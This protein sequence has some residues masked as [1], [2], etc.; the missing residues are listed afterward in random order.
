M[1][2]PCLRTALLALVLLP[3][4]SA[5]AQLPL[6]QI[7]AS[8]F[9]IDGTLRE[10][11]PVTMS[12]LGSGADASLRYAVAYDANGLYVGAEVHDDRMVRTA[13]PGDLEDA[14]V[15]TLAMPGRGAAL[16]A[17]E[18][19]LYAGQAGQSA[20]MVTAGPLGARRR[21]AVSGARIVEA[22]LSSG[23][24]YTLEA[25]I[26]WGAVTGHD[27]W[28]EGRGSIR[29]RDVDQ[30]AHPT[31]EAEP[32]LAV[33]ERAHL[34]RL[35][36]L[37]PSG[38]EAARLEEFLRPRDLSAA[39]PHHEFRIDVAGDARPEH[40]MLIDRFVVVMGP[41]YQDGRGYAFAELGIT[42]IPDLI[43]A[44][45]QDVTGDGKA[46]LLVVLRQRSGAGSR[47]LFQVLSVTA[48]TIV[49]IFGI[50]QRKET[51]AG[52]V[53]AT[54]RVERGRRGQAATIITASGAAHGLDGT[55]L[56]ESPPADV[57]GILLPWG[58]VAERRYRWDG[59]RFA[60][61]SE[62]A[63]P[64]YEDASAA[65]PSTTTTTTTTTTT[66]PSAPSLEQLLAAFRREAHI[67]D[68]TRPSFDLTGNVV[69]SSAP[70]RVV[71][72]GREL[73]VVGPEFRDGTG[74][75]RFQI[76]CEAADLID[77]SLADLTG[78][79]RAEVLFRIRQA[80]GDVRREVLLVH[81]FTPTEFPT[82]LTREIA[83]E[84]GTNRIENQ[85]VTIGGHLE[86]RPGTARG[87]SASSW[88]Y[89]DAPSTDG[90]D[91]PLIPWRDSAV[92]FR[93]RSG[94]LVPE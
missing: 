38:G 24:G 6:T 5:S 78:E 94:H 84:L 11:G 91:L 79:G 59:H 90:V 37:L 14:I 48:D 23:A 58:P 17:T 71:V 41:G 46:E 16:T 31:V 44:E 92:R 67:A 12:T 2:F 49:P 63:S 25:F 13:H 56:R 39:R 29:L 30:S 87:W 72:Y 4:A 42:S 3:S 86:I 40:V 7:D 65:R 50:E 32:A 62:R 57:E 20:A 61:I 18:I 22:P 81:M 80:L 45:A 54:V 76:P 77:V 26:P 85:V 43:S 8:T 28:E 51:P 75:F 33:V 35:P 10:W 47:D 21:S 70:E 36:S 83:R 73:V 9:D 66:A 74:W 27:R 19:W 55:T 52:S 15:L 64:H 88:P 34:D 82:I 53:D 89:S 69:G 60:Q 93:V 1:T 68:R